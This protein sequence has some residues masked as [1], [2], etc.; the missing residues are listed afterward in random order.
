MGVE[1]LAQRLGMGARH[2]RRLF[3]EHLGATPIA[4]AQTRRVHLAK[5]FL[6]ETTLPITEIA[7]CAGFSSIRRFNAAF[8]QIYGKTPSELRRNGN[9][10]VLAEENGKLQIKLSYRPPFDWQPLIQFLQARAIPGVEAIDEHA[11][12]RAVKIGETSGIIEVQSVEGQ[13][14]LLL[15]VPPE[16]SKGLTQIVE[17]VRC[18]FDLKADP[19]AITNH[20]ERDVMLA[21]AIHTHPGMRVP[22]AWDGFEIAIRAILGQQ[23]SVKGATTLAGRLVRA[24]GERVS[25]SNRHG[26][27]FL[28]PT[29]ERLSQARFTH[30]GLPSK[31]A[32]AIRRL[33]KA[34]LDGELVFTSAIGL[35]EAIDR[36]VAL[37]GIGL[38]TAHYIAMRALGEPDAFP[39]GDLGLRRAASE[40]GGS[41]LTEAQLLQRAE[42]WRPWRAYA[43]MYLWMNHASRQNMARK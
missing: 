1:E 41:A 40:N 7:F 8:H 27:S 12:R 4:V 43:T 25:I 5:K 42:A 14:H 19:A 34:V 29:P 13:P 37:P 21:P 31:R 20:L 9:Q 6:D 33:A 18:L 16:L 23:V 35:D 2:L 3:D 26:L 22:G 17:R 10:T 28:F 39:S 15:S 11:Y 24:Y 38:W 32:E 30:V 36:L